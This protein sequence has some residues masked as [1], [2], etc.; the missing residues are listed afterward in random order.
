MLWSGVDLERYPTLT[1]TLQQEGAGAESSGQVV[2]SGT[3]DA[4]ADD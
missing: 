4:D 2:L 3:V 1:V